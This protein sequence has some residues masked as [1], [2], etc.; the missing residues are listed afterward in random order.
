SVPKDKLK[1]EIERQFKS[2][3]DTALADFQG[4]PDAGH[5]GQRL[6]KVKDVTVDLQQK[7]L[8][9]N[10]WFQKVSRQP[11]EGSVGLDGIGLRMSPPPKLG[12]E[13]TFTFR[14]ATEGGYATIGFDKDGIF[15]RNLT[16][17]LDAGAE[18]D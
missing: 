10:L 15:F 1:E 11:T 16:V 4:P 9:A 7:R 2:A 17:A 8:T 6:P 3:L 12:L 14:G 5:P 13:T 18:I